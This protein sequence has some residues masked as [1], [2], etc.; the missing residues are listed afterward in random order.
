MNPLTLLTLLTLAVEPSKPAAL[1]GTVTLPLQDVL[2]LQA[3]RPAA[4]LPP[5]LDALV[6]KTTLVGRLA[7]D[8]LAVDAH[9][10]VEVLADGRWSHLPLFE[11]PAGARLVEVG[12]V[13]GATVAAHEGRV[14]FLS[15]QPGRYAFDLKLE[16]RAGREGGLRRAKLKFLRAVSPAPLSLTADAAAFTLVGEAVPSGEGWL[17]LPEGADLTVAWRSDARA[18]AASVAVRPAMEPSIPRAL[19]TWV[20]TL[21]GRAGLR[22]RYQL[23][24]DREQPLELEVPAGHRVERVRVNGVQV[25]AVEEGQ[26][27]RLRVAPARVGETEGTLEV[28]LTRDLGVFHLS[29]RLALT[30]PRV[31]WPVAELYATAY[32]PAVFTY[33]REGG[34]LEAHADE[35]LPMLE[36]ETPLP[37]K[38]LQFRQFLVSASSPSLELGYSVDIAG[39]Y[40]R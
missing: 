39:S 18:K 25:A 35:S 32:L 16:L 6:V 14:V 11:L 36:S 24:L 1:S 20:S 3:E 31:S 4:K 8:S 7:E 26:T 9:V 28:S 30:L 5:P 19:A 15:Q 27:H 34:S 21:E 13:E 23:R 40:F 37:G 12:K 17:I 38:A 22:L 33:R 29:G 10:E 2:E